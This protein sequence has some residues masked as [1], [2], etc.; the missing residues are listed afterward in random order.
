MNQRHL[1]PTVYLTSMILVYSRYVPNDEEMIKR[2]IS[3]L[4]EEIRQTVTKEWEGIKR[5]FP[6]ALSVMH[7]FVQRI[8]DQ[9][10]QNFLEIL[11]NAQLAKSPLSYL[12]ALSIA[13]TETANLVKDLCE[14]DKR[15]IASAEGAVSLSSII[16]R[17]FED[18]FVPYI[19]NERYIT[20][21]RECLAAAFKT[22]LEAFNL[23]LV[24]IGPLITV[25]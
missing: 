20:S 17:S 7:N 21:E 13:H 22:H 19:D 1:E 9:S 8:F 11:L 18:L 24:N 14:F 25:I 15:D 23:F 2:D 6:N 12:V 10:I 4:Y 3:R 16:A 5:I